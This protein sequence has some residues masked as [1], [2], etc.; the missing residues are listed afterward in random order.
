MIQAKFTKRVYTFS[1][2]DGEKTIEKFMIQGGPDPSEL[3]D[4]TVSGEGKRLFGTDAVLEGVRDFA[5]E[6]NLEYPE[7]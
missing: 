7:G 4:E 3:Q 1:T 5:K 6:V 2:P